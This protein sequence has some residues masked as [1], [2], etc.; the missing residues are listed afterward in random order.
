M[1]LSAR[2]HQA[3]DS[4]QRGETHPQVT[5]LFF[6]DTTGSASTDEG[7]VG[8]LCPGGAAG[9]SDLHLV[10]HDTKLPCTSS[11]PAAL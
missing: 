9:L 2:R 1:R 11:T 7:G 10:T 3:N 6:H 5:T 4:S 8:L